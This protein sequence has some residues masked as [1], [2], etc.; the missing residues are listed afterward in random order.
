MA[1]RPAELSPGELEV[2]KVLWQGESN[3]VREVMER[4]H[5]RGRRI[6]YTT[7]LTFLN[8]LEAKGYVKSDKAGLA[9]VYTPRHSREKITRKRLRAVADQLFDGAV[10]PM[11]LQL[12]KDERFTP[13]EI[14]QFRALIDRLDKAA[15]EEQE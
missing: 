8:R 7:V 2:L 9:Y 14:E 11:V 5:A 10:A 6:A 13:E 3:T 15:E 12:M 1:K 4:L